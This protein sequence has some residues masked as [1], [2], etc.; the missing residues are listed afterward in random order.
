MKNQPQD[1]LPFVLCFQQA[2]PQKS[3]VL[4]G[5]QSQLDVWIKHGACSRKAVSYASIAGPKKVRGCQTICFGVKWHTHTH[6]LTS[7][8][9]WGG[10]HVLQGG[11]SLCDCVAIVPRAF[12][13]P[14]PHSANVICL[15]GGKVRSFL[16]P[17][18]TWKP[19]LRRIA[20]HKRGLS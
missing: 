9:V 12:C 1:C 16:F 2:N 6:T 8:S 4:I 20:P 17:E 14:P 11:H 13:P 5:L 3:A 7:F 10:S 15:G 19:I 18:K